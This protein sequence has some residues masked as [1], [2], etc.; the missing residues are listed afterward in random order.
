MH[1]IPL[2]HEDPS[3][4]TADDQTRS[5]LL[6]S[7]EGNTRQEPKTSKYAACVEEYDESSVTSGSYD[8]SPQ[9]SF[10]RSSEEGDEEEDISFSSDA[11]SARLRPRSNASSQIPTRTKPSNSIHIQIDPQCPHDVTIHSEL[12]ATDDLDE[13]LEQYSR[14]VRLGR[15]E[16]AQRYFDYC[17]LHFI[18][19]PYIIDLYC[20]SLFARWDF[21]ALSQVEEKYASRLRP[22]I[23]KASFHTRLELARRQ[24]GNVL[25]DERVSP[26]IQKWLDDADFIEE[27]WPKLDSTEIRT[28]SS[29]LSLSNTNLL[30][31]GELAQVYSNLRDEGRIWDFRDLLENLLPICRNSTYRALE[32]LL[33]NEDKKGEDT[34]ENLAQLV[35]RIREDWETIA[36][37]EE[38]SFAL[39][40]IFTTLT[41]TSMGARTNAMVKTIFELATKHALEVVGI[42]STNTK[43][44]PYLRWIITKVLLEQYVDHKITGVFAL[45]SHLNSLPGLCL[46]LEIQVPMN[47]AIIYAPVDDETPKWQPDP[48]TTSGHDGALRTVLRVAEELGDTPMQAT[49]LQLL[50]YQCSQPKLL[51]DKLGDLWRSTGS[52]LG[53]LNTRLYCY[54]PASLTTPESRESIRREILL[55]GEIPSRGSASRAKNMILR[56]L[57]SNKEEKDV[58]LSRALRAFPYNNHPRSLHMKKDDGG[59]SKTHHRPSLIV[60]PRDATA[61]PSNAAKQFRN[62]AEAELNWC[63]PNQLRAN[64]T[65]G[66]ETSPKETSHLP[67]NIKSTQQSTF[68]SRANIQPQLAAGAQPASDPQPTPGVQPVPKPPQNAQYADDI[69]HWLGINLAGR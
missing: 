37:D 53:Y 39:L 13:E 11:A 28:L 52:P 64:P 31:P 27:H 51:L 35:E 4:H 50:I 30:G 56:A 1:R 59:P 3:A 62:H 38:S 29:L 26:K 9:V 5:H 58:Y 32:T 42:Q 44:R 7:V 66:C 2:P 6:P 23:L 21:H 45:A 10:T 15:F 43:S 54:I 48:S 46:P 69:S 33:A 22:G 68:D 61:G 47:Y 65:R 17:L 20:R 55:A 14:L 25:E 24:C 12:S 16:D 34:D 40:D 63:G 67:P 41:L 57:S 18:D 49:C 60:P 8:K 19:N 36:P